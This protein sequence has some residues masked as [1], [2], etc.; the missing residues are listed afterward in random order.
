MSKKNIKKIEVSEKV[1]LHWNDDH[2]IPSVAYPDLEFLFEQMTKKT[3]EA[4]FRPGGVFLDVGCGR[5]VD[6]IQLLSRGMQGVGVE[7]SDY[8]L[9]EAKKELSRKQLHMD[10]VRAFGE[11]LP[12]ADNTFDV[13]YCKGALDHFYNPQLAVR[14]MARVTKPDGWLVISVANFESLG[15][16]FGRFITER[17][18]NPPPS[19]LPWDTPED[20]TIRL[21][22]HVLKT[23][24]SP[25]LDNYKIWGKSLL[26]GVPGWGTFLHKIP[27]PLA[28]GILRSL[29]LAAYVFSSFADILILRGHPRQQLPPQS[30][31]EHKRPGSFQIK[32]QVNAPNP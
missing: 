31:Y 13:T 23:L 29:N 24:T 7:V 21:D 4:A 5:A 22:Y 3:L 8:M 11:D 14:E 25:F 12:F 28:F 1:D 16:R 15:F 9:E 19:P 20:H 10:L 17:K 30:L 26:F 2:V 18:K 27:R 32:D 6:A